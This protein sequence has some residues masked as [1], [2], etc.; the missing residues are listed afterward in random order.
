MYLFNADVYIF[1]NLCFLCIFCF[2][3]LCVANLE[4]VFFFYYKYAKA[5][6]TLLSWIENLFLFTLM[7]QFKLTN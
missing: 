5:F 7:C 4:Y 2:M 1:H 6:A 3:H